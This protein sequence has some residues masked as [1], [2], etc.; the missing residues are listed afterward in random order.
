[1]VV[2]W[3]V[4]VVGWLVVVVVVSGGA[5]VV[6]E[7]GGVVVVVGAE[8]VVVGAVVVVVFGAVGVV[9]AVVVVVFRGGSVVVVVSAGAVAV[10]DGSAGDRAGTA[11]ALTWATGARATCTIRVGPACRAAGPDGP[12]RTHAVAVSRP[13]PG[14]AERR[15]R[16]WGLDTS[17]PGEWSRGACS[18]QRL[19]GCFLLV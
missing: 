4:V 9:G 3:L 11:S 15:R 5:V 16:T 2:G 17:P 19:A 1:M 8:V 18:L 13:R 7:L 6:G 14:T 12:E 10:A